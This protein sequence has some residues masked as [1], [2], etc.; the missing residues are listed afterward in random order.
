MLILVGNKYLLYLS[1]DERFARLHSKRIWAHEKNYL[2][3]FT[4]LDL[5]KNE[6]VLKGN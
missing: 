3:E 4:K 6:N 1:G 2:D 5:L